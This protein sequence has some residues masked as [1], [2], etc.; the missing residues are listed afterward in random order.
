MKTLFNFIVAGSVGILAGFFAAL[1]LQA[2]G[3]MTDE[4]EARQSYLTFDPWDVMPDEYDKH[5]DDNL[6][7]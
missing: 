2:L 7:N 3:K 4:E 5:K 6:T 1:F